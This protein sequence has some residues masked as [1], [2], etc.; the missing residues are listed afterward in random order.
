MKAEELMIND[1]VLFYHTR[2]RCD[3]YGKI[4]SIYQRE[5]G[6]NPASFDIVTNDGELVVGVSKR[7]VKPIPL[8]PEILSNNGFE[9]QNI[10]LW[11]TIYNPKYKNHTI[12]AYYDEDD[13]DV[14]IPFRGHWVFDENYAFDYVHELQHCLRLC[15]LNDLAENFKV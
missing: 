7:N 1:A 13:E 9:I 4:V 12:V 8:T 3:V 6:L 2:L 10:K 15:G 5:V 14:A 11:Y